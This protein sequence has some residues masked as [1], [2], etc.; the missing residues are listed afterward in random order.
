MIK[1]IK[2]FQLQLIDRKIMEKRKKLKQFDFNSEKQK[3][4]NFIKIIE[5]IQKEF[6]ELSFDKT[7]SVETDKIP[8]TGNKE[9]IE[10]SKK[11][12][13]VNL[14]EHIKNVTKLVDEKI[15]MENIHDYMVLKLLALLHDAGKSKLL[16]KK[17][18]I[19]DKL[20]HEEASYLYAEKVL[21]NTDFEHV[22][23]FFKKDTRY[24]NFLKEIDRIARERELEILKRTKG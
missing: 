22:L 1:W 9:I 23:N 20:S 14:Y 5:Q 21:K 19:P 2:I 13:N 3:Y 16:R 4:E 7:P 18:Q 6:L 12:S 24:L 10:R 15:S 17:Y 8:V 11:L